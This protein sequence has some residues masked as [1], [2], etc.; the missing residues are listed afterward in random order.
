MTNLD[1]MR[2]F[3]GELER[4]TEKI[5]QIASKIV[6]KELNERR[7]NKPKE[8]GDM[9]MIWGAPF[10]EDIETKK[11]EDYIHDLLSKKPMILI[12]KNC[13]NK[14]Y[15]EIIQ[16][17]FNRDIIVYSPEYNKKIATC[18]EYVKLIE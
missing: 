7:C 18:M 1:N 16:M 10:T 17:T 9:V 4:N 3:E 14:Y 8:I 12:E 15:D 6:K 11:N 13:I 2:D 5:R